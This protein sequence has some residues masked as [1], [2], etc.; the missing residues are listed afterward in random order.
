MSGEQ[1]APHMTY[2]IWLLLAVERVYTHN[3]Q[4]FYGHFFCGG[5]YRSGCYLARH[6]VITETC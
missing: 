6:N 4:W 3:P 1:K 2:D 5:C